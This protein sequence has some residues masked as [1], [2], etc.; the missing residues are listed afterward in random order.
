[1]LYH[2]GRHYFL[3]DLKGQSQC[4]PCTAGTAAPSEGSAK[5]DVCPAGKYSGVDKAVTCE[6]CGRGYYQPEEESTH[7]MSCLWGKTTKAY[8]ATA[9]DQCYCEFYFPIMLKVTAE[10]LLSSLMS[11]S[12]GSSARLDLDMLEAQKCV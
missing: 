2:P 10:T 5:C 4:K 7:C 3:Q 6:L 8:G 12:Q 9:Q 1:M 11:V